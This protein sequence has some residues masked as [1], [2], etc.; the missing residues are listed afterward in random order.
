M[1]IFLNGGGD[2]K[3][4]AET[5][6]RFNEIIDH[7]KPL[8]YVPLAMESDMYDGCYEWINEEMNDVG[9]PAIEMVRSAEELAEKKLKD[10][11]ALFFGGGN[12]FKLLND[13]KTSGAFEKIKEYIEN[14]GV[15]FGGSAGAIIFGK[16]LESCRLD[17]PNEVGL[18]DI[19]GF[20]VL[21]G[22]SL[23]CHYTNRSPQKDS[24][25]KKYLLELSKRMKIIALSEE[26]TIFINENRIEVI[27]AKPYYC[28]ENGKIYE[29]GSVTKE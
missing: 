9:I 11:C 2:G 25:S 3:Q 19:S 28:F 1:K 24:E 8:L 21:N 6:K 18:E 16:N 12:T 4:T 17:D 23:L 26:N 13:L 29:N 7:S 27:G 22:I 14:G 5:R 20:N 15:I 10:Y